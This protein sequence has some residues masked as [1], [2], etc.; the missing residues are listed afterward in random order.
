MN[1]DT[2]VVEPITQDIAGRLLFSAFMILSNWAVLAILTS[3]VSDNMISS[4]IKL[5][6]ETKQKD[7]ETAFSSRT[8]QLTQFLHEVDKGDSNGKITKSEWEA[9]LNDA[10][11]LKYLSELTDLDATTLHEIFY[12]ISEEHDTGG[13]GG[14]SEP[15]L[16]C[17]DFVE[18][19]NHD[20]EVATR[21]HVIHQRY[22]LE[23]ITLSRMQELESNVQTK[24]DEL[25]N[26]LEKTMCSLNHGD[27]EKE[28]GV[29][30][31][32]QQHH[33]EYPPAP[34]DFRTIY[35][36]RHEYLRG[37]AKTEEGVYNPNARRQ[38]HQEY[39][40]V[41]PMA[42]SVGSSLRHDHRLIGHDRYEI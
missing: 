31:A 7:T 8:R 30:S 25:R 20:R 36:S 1:G 39:L 3:V 41:P 18:Y 14:R 16:T 33:Q 4:T 19:L 32:R 13:E 34:I 28:K 5:D 9:M 15:V 40:P 27:R 2:S 37:A 11:L 21:R 22:W 35:S 42:N 23:K 12:C 10:K 26:M 6:E 17:D 38:Y 24:F 29:Y